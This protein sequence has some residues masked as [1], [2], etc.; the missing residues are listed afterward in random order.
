MNC[1]A[2]VISYVELPVEPSLIF[3]PQKMGRLSPVPQ[4]QLG[5]AVGSSLK[6]VSQ[7][8]PQIIT[9]NYHALGCHEV[10]PTPG[11]SHILVTI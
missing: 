8:V 5:L 6:T 2:T 4:S 3:D 7:I 1:C 9:L 11:P 10:S